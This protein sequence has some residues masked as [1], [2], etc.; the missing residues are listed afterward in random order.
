MIATIIFDMDGVIIDS[1]PTHQQMEFEMY[2]ELGL[3]IS[4]EEHKG[5]VGTSSID[6]WNMIKECHQLER[7]PEELLLYGRQKYWDALDQNR[8][9]LVVGSRELMSKLYQNN[10]V[11]QVASSATRPTVDKVIEHFNLASMISHRIG[12]N[13]VKKSKPNSEIFIKAAGQSE[14][15]PAQCLV[16]EDSANGVKAA[17]DAGMQCIG[18]AN[19]ETGIQDLS[20][21]D[22]V[23]FDL[24]EIDLE[25]VRSI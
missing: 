6:M 17:K 8:V 19:P 25:M 10:F 15:F 23:V 9:P 14:S 1:E 13:E 12:G 7:T 3:N 18:Y 16:I 4:P 20:E 2:K 5:Y 21:A 11:I 24:S 22:F